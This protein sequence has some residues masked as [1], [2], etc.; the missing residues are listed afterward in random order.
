MFKVG[1]LAVYPAHGVGIIKAIELKDIMGEEQPFY[2][3]KIL[4][5]DAT[6]MIPK[7][8]A[9]SVGLREVISVDQ[10]PKI[11]EILKEKKIVIDRQTWNKRYKEYWEKI[12]TGSVFEIATVVRDLVMLKHDKELS[13]G[14]RKMM[15]TALSLLIKEMSVA[16]RCDECAIESELDS[17]FTA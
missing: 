5:N 13:F 14:E 16:R 6:I 1:D 10:I 2:I 12:K 9:T 11:F 4:A 8:G 17:I 3:M 15:D 7:N